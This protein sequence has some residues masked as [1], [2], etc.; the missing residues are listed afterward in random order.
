MSTP[1]RNPNGVIVG[2]LQVSI[3][4][5]YRFHSDVAREYPYLLSPTKKLIHPLACMLQLINKDGHFGNSHTH[6]C[7]A[8]GLCD[9]L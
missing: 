3:A 2:V 4:R 8:F 6:N 5:Y 1:I 9:F 7:L